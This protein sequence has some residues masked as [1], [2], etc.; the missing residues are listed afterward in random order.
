M[1]TDEKMQLVDALS[2]KFASE[3][4][5]DSMAVLPSVV[6]KYEG[7]LKNFLACNFDDNLAV[8]I[9]ERLAWE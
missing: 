9:R 1:T 3:A 2:E 5:R 4:E 6:G 7:F 8:C